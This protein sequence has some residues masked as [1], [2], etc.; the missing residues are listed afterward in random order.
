MGGPLNKLTDVTVRKTKTDPKKTKKLSDG[1]GLYLE[2]NKNG[3]RYWRLAYRFGGKQ[4]TLALGVYPSTP[5]SEAREKAET[6]RKNIRDGL[7]PGQLK[8]IQGSNGSESANTFEAT[9]QEWLVRFKQDWTESHFKSISGRLQRDIFPFIGKQEISSIT[10]PELLSV[11]NRIVTRGHLENAH[12]ALSNAGQVFKYGI[13]SGKCDRNP[14]ADI[15]GAVPRPAVKHMS[16]ITDPAQV[17]ALMQAIAAYPGDTIT[18]CALQLIAHTFLRSK[19]LRLG[20]WQE[21]D[22]EKREWKIP[23]AKMKGR[24]RDK[25]ANPNGF[26][27]VPLAEQTLAILREV[28]AISGD[29]KF[30]FPG[31]R[32]VTRPIS[33]MTMTN[34]LRRMGYGKDEMHVHGFR[35]MART[36]IRQELGY[37]EEPIERQLGHAVRG[38]LGAA[39][40]RADFIEERK[41]MM[42]DWAN[43]LEKL[44]AQAVK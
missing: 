3:S 5:L 20:E 37:D 23:V 16:A 15:V 34:A 43:Y 40:N 28:Q 19:E 10:A 12:R 2:F 44:T 18:R 11:I 4:K 33:D 32:T 17:G 7:D 35:A 21:I 13:S 31:A 36:L 38:P 8:K 24:K 22:F 29:G 42:Q 30:I 1:G 9:A 41:R 14:A 39:Y 26:H 6:A 27:L 25:E